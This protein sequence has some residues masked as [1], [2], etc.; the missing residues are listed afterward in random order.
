MSEQTTYLKSVPTTRNLSNGVTT[1][2]QYELYQTFSFGDKVIA[3]YLDYGTSSQRTATYEYYTDISD[4]GYGKL[5]KRVDFDGKW[6]KYE[7]DSSGRLIKEVSPFGDASDT[8][9]EN[10][11][12]VITYDYTKL[13]SSESSDSGDN[14]RWRRRIVMTCG[15]ETGRQ[16]RQFFS[17][18]EKVITAVVPG[19]A[20]NAEGNK[21]ETTEFYEYYDYQR[22]ENIRRETRIETPDGFAE[23]I[24]YVDDYRYQEDPWQEIHLTRKTTVRKFLT[25]ALSR[26]VEV[27]NHFGTVESYRRYALTG[28]TELLAEGYDQTIDRYGRPLVKTD[29]D[30]NVTT[31][32]YY[33]AQ[34]QDGNYTNSIPFDHVRTV[35]PDGSVLVEAFDIW[36]NRIFSLYDGITT[37]Y[38]YDAFGNVT[39]TIITGRN[40]G[41]LTTSTAYNDDEVKLSETDA[42]GN[43]TTY[44]YGPCWNARTD[45]LGNVFRNEYFLDGRL[46]NVKVNGA[47]KNYCTYEIVN[48]ELVKTE[49]ASATE[50]NQT[51]TGFDGNIRQIVFPDGYV[52]NILFDEYGRQSV[53]EDS[54]GNKTRYAY[55]PVTGELFR[56]WENGVLTEFVSGTAVDSETGEIYSFEQTYSYYRNAPAL[57]NE[58]RT[59][60]NGRKTREFNAGSVA[61]SAKKYSGNGVIIETKTENGIVTTNTY[62]NARLQSARN[63]ASGL[64]QYVYDEFDRPLGYDYTEDSVVKTI[65]N[66]LDGNGNS[67]SITQTAGTDSRTVN[68]LYDALNQKTQETTPEGQTV[69][70]T[71]DAQGNITA[72]SGNVY[73]QEYTYDLQGRITGITTYRSQSAA[74]AT[75][76]TYDNR[77]RMQSRIY[78]DNVTEQFS[79]RGDGN[80]DSVTNARGQVIG[81]RYDAMNRLVAVQGADIYWEFAYDYRGLLLRAC[82][83]HWYQNFGYDEYGNLTSENYSDIPN[84]EIAYFYDG[85]KRFTGYSFDGQQV[86]YSY[87]PTTGRLER[88]SIGKW[89]FNYERIAGSANLAQ[90]IAKRNNRIIQTVSRVYNSLG[91]LTD[92]G[93]YGYTVNLDGRREAATQTDGKTW[94]Y[95]YDNFNQVTSGVLSNGNDPVSSHSYVYDLIGNR[96]SSTDNGAV[97]AYTANTLNQYTEVDSVEFEYDADGNMLSD[98]QFD[99]EYDA[100][101][102]LI[103]V[104]NETEKKVFVYDF[105]GR[106]IATESYFKSGEEW[107]QSTRRRYIYQG[108]NVIAEFVNGARNKT[109][110]WGEDLS[111][112]LQGAG[113]V[114]G[115]L[116]EQNGNGDYLPVYD[117][118]GNI[119]AYK[120]DTGSVVSSY[121]Y[122]PFGNV[123]AHAGMDFTYKFSTKPQDELSELYYYGYRFYQPTVG[124]WINRDPIRENGGENL[125]SYNFANPVCLFDSIG[126][127]VFTVRKKNIDLNAPGISVE[128]SMDADPSGFS[129]DWTP[130][131]ADKT[132]CKCGDFHLSQSISSHGLSGYSTHVDANKKERTLHTKSG[133]KTP[134]PVM[135]PKGDVMY[136]YIDSPSTTKGNWLIG[137]TKFTITAVA[138]CVPKKEP[139]KWF[140]IDSINFTFDNNT[141]TLSLPP[142]AISDGRGGF[143]GIGRAPGWHWKNAEKD[144]RKE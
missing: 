128:A 120:N 142:G 47:V 104:A 136:S 21:V 95:A 94:A 17:G 22:D 130:S 90:T 49:Y 71:Y 65:R 101:N 119:I 125:Y 3:R 2:T 123:I 110:V 45:A 111:G 56:Q 8:A 86:N 85:Y 42:N 117:G 43:V 92:I 87:S 34:I 46:K 11:C 20:W 36:E 68:Y 14:P 103:S 114:G 84:T 112:A 64:V 32:E 23:E 29:V 19:A 52:Q 70:Y 97:K 31:F 4:Y 55:S 40:G 131:A 53:I 60:R 12:Q 122:D 37:F 26:E 98:G 6:T 63:A 141:R 59:Y 91:D 105:A 106:R 135:L 75:T 51:V 124:R 9:A 50:W 100:Q 126:L 74:E 121:A 66:V 81:C 10:L 144:W 143:S 89:N 102:Q 116:L 58:T 28:E 27:K 76:F 139:S 1:A 77:G 30:G 73:P 134:P 24:S 132:K 61:L 57:M 13:D 44:T 133:Y 38:H 109:Y 107:V 129:V 138:I 25:N 18:R 118:N 67:L 82:D 62:V 48:H 93:G 113:G 33:T 54:C 137:I 127:G 99:Y 83:G 140:V 79:Y 35:K 5:A 69:G 115:L 41:T 16:Y 108:W 80:I 72:V 15:Q 96:T 39:G 78:P 88:V 7:Y